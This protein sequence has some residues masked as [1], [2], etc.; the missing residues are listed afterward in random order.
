MAKDSKR[1]LGAST[2]A[3]R[4]GAPA[5]RDN[6]VRTVG[7]PIQRGSTVLID[8]AADLYSATRTTYGRPNALSTH[9]AL[10]EAI[11]ELEGGVGAEL[12]P[13][14]LASITG[15]MLALL[16]AGDEV[17]AVDCC[18]APIRRF[19]DG[20]LKRFG[21]T[22]RYLPP[23]ATA[24]DFEAALT[25]ATRMIVL[26]SPGSLTFELQD[27]PAIAAMARARGVLTL[28]DNTYGAGHLFKPLAHGVD[29]SCQALTKYVGGHSDILMGS[30]AVAS[31]ELLTRLR[32][33][34]R[35]VG[36]TVSPDDAYQML[37]GLRT[38][39]TRLKTHGESGLAVAAF[40]AEQPEV[41]RVIHPGRPDHPDHALF[42]RD[43]LGPNGL[44]AFVLKGASEAQVLAFLDALELF[45]LGFS[46]GGFESL[47]IPCDPQLKARTAELWAAEGPLIRLHVGLEDPA[48][49]IADLRRGLDA[50]GSGAA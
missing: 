36:S 27:V 43:F 8:K 26:E 19:C 1:D 4:A 37:R 34:S 16:K 50:L 18:Y 9:K 24:A 3:I 32:I 17:L 33:Y 31:P 23:R 38:L 7:P 22:T 44:F 40:L 15:P 5:G 11:A 47:A 42:A 39:P 6:G 20:F 30:A 28:I 21:V 14:G 49:L 48:D 10:I 35:D 46:W 25:P 2:R 41:A 12:Y 29:V 45:G 13:C